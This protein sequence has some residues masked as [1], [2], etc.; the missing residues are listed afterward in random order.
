[1]R[2]L[3][4]RGRILSTLVIALASLG[5][6]MGVS[7]ADVKP[8]PIPPTEKNKVSEL[9]LLLPTSPETVLNP[10]DGLVRRA[11]TRIGE[12][13]SA[14]CRLRIVLNFAAPTKDID[15]AI[16]MARNNKTCL[17]LLVTR[18]GQ[19]VIVDYLTLLGSQRKSYDVDS[20]PIILDLVN[21]AQD[22]SVAQDQLMA[23]NVEHS[24][25]GAQVEVGHE[26]GIYS[27]TAHAREL[28]LEAFSGAAMSLGG[29]SVQLDRRGNWNGSAGP[30]EVALT[31]PDSQ[32]I[33]ARK[34]VSPAHETRNFTVDLSDLDPGTYTMQVSSKAFNAPSIVRSVR[35]DGIPPSKIL[36]IVGLL[37]V[38]CSTATSLVRVGLKGKFILA[39]FVSAT[40]IVTFQSASHFVN[41]SAT[42]GRLPVK[43]VK[44]GPGSSSN[45]STALGPVDTVLE[46]QLALWRIAG[47]TSTYR[48]TLP[49]PG[50]ETTMSSASFRRL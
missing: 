21:F 12:N 32:V 22:E 28:E 42:V 34:S 4:A 48:F 35:V 20:G 37:L 38:L 17:Q 31:D 8:F 14:L 15:G 41:G 29:L 26:T 47:E 1:M 16:S 45:G 7:V 23:V 18:N 5:C 3:S 33:V 10:G 25:K 2:L 49:L 50:E 13:Q 9:S 44:V 19:T 39:F 6:L 30:V 11:A 40:V 36:L 27:T 24:L 46:K 43:A